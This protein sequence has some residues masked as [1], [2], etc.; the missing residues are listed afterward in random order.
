M[1]QFVDPPIEW[2]LRARRERTLVREEPPEGHVDIDTAPWPCKEAADFSWAKDLEPYV[3]HA[4][5]ARFVHV[6]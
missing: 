1:R 5:C 2:N 6:A 3:L 4:F